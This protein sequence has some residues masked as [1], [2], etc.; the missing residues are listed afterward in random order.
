MFSLTHA[1]NGEKKQ[2]TRYATVVDLPWTSQDGNQLSIISK[3][4][5]VKREPLCLFFRTE[6]T[7]HYNN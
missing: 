4:I 2:E 6:K 1:H 7:R 5:I 3:M